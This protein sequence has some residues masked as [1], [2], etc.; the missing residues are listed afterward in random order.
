MEQQDTNNPRPLPWVILH[1]VLA[2]FVMLFL[3]TSLENAGID[4]IK[5]FFRTSYCYYPVLLFSIGG[6]LIVLNLCL[7]L[8]GAV[9]LAKG[10]PYLRPV[11]AGILVLAIMVSILSMIAL[12][13]QFHHPPGDAAQASART[14]FWTRIGPVVQFGPFVD[15]RADASAS[16]V[17]WYFDPFPKEDPPSLLFGREPMPEKM[18]I[19]KEATGDGRRHEFHLTGLSPSTSYYYQIPARGDAVHSFRTGP[20]RGSAEPF[21]FMAV[22]DTGNTR[23]GGYAVS[24]Y[25]EVLMAAGAWYSSIHAI[26]A[27][28]IHGGD[29]VRFGSDLDGWHSHFSSDEMAVSVPGAVTPGNHELLRDGG[30]N[31]RYF[32]GQPDYYIVDHGNAR[33]FFIHPFDGPGKTLDGPVLTTGREQ[34]RWLRHELAKRPGSRWTIIVIHIPLLST[35]DYGVNEL[36]MAQYFELFRKHKVDLVISGHDHN[37]DSFYLDENADWGGTIYLVTGTGGSSLD[38]YIMDRPARRWLGWRHDRNLP[39][40]LYQHDR[41]TVSSHRYGE[42]SWGFSDISIL[43]DTMTVTYCRWL[44]FDR[45]LAITGQERHAWDMVHLDGPVLQKNGLVMAVPVITMVKRKKQ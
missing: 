39:G 32:Y 43:D 9:S 13:L 36:L 29:M 16:M 37:F 24:Y 40:G 5:I 35:G 7:A 41:Y 27:F 6:L 1:L 26:P 18:T 4:I 15:R 33:I 22:A 25:G 23:R 31:F 38:S 2:L 20:A 30:A 42:L 12:F 19:L 14:R 11:T 21:R 17:I 10:I 44:D 8:Y 34:Y 28:R 3:L 45:Y